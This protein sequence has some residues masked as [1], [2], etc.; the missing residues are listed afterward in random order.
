MFLIKLFVK[1]A[2]VF[3]KLKQKHSGRNRLQQV[4]FSPNPI[5]Y[6]FKQRKIECNDGMYKATLIQVALIAPLI[7]NINPLFFCH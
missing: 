6:S 5:L 4:K 1:M 2:E 3:W 7:I